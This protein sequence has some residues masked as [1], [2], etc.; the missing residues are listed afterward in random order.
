MRRAVM[1]S[2]VS[3]FMG[4]VSNAVIKWSNEGGRLSSNVMTTS[5]SFIG[6]S[7]HVSWSARDFTLLMWSRMS[8]PSSILMVKNL[9]LMNKILDKLLVSWMLH[10]V[11]HASAGPLHPLMCANSLSTKL[12]AMMA[13]AFL[14]RRSYAFLISSLAVDGG[15][16]SEP[17]HDLPKVFGRHH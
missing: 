1:K 12:V 8:A 14:H 15:G 4:R 2:N 6:T 10:K 17:L 3:S 11:F 5:S 16:N 7:K 9:R 13:K